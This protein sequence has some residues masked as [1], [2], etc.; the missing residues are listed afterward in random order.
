MAFV[1]ACH[2]IGGEAEQQQLNSCN[3]L[4]ISTAVS[5]DDPSSKGRA[6]RWLRNEPFIMSCSL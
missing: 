1:A 6:Y 5:E 3:F 2:I 4:D